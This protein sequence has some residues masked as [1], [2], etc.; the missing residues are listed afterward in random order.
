M[1]KREKIKELVSVDMQFLDDKVDSALL[2]YAERSG[3]NKY[4]LP[5]YGYQAIK[6]ILRRD[7]AYG[8]GLYSKMQLLFSNMRSD[9]M[10]AVLYKMQHDELWKTI[11]SKNLPRWDGLDVAIIGLGKIGWHK[12]TGVMYSVPLCVHCLSAN[13]TDGSNGS[14]S[15][16][17]AMRKLTENIIPVSL[18]NYTPWFLTPVK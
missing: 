17:N 2:G 4:I 6:A 12:P 9:D 14:N 10:P 1:L 3:R 15:T 11:N 16:M 18:G 8:A 7:G 13:S 5:C